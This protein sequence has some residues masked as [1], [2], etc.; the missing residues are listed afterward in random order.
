MLEFLHISNEENENI[1]NQSVTSK[2]IINEYID[3]G[4]TDEDMELY[5]VIANDISEV[6]ED[7]DSKFLSDENRPSFVALVAYAVKEDTEKL[8]KEWLPDFE[9]QGDLILDQK[10][11][12][13]HMK[14]NFD[15][16]LFREDI[17]SA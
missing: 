2:D 3:K 16:F 17:K 5:E 15:D 1:E 10:E 7:I 6:I 12:Y 4:V 11:N 8:L 9:N 13:L 14:A